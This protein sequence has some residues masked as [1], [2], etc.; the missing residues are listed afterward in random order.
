MTS[1]QKRSYEEFSR[2]WTVPFVSGRLSR[3]ALF[4][5][6]GPL[7]VEIGFGMGIATAI[8]AGQNP[9]VNYLGIEVHRPGIGR[10]LWEI[11]KRGLSNIKIIEG[12]AVEVLEAMDF[13]VDSFHIF[14]P[15]PWPKKRHHKR[16]LIQRPFTGLL[17]RRLK[18]GGYLYMVTDWEDYGHWALAELA[19]TAGLK[20][21]YGDFAGGA[22][23]DFAEEGAGGFARGFAPAQHWRPKTKFEKKGI[24]KNHQVWELMF[25]RG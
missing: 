9:G 11:E 16:L 17:A 5:G 13:E 10:L 25:E 14:F 19:G 8:I 12:D 1:A 6:T 20:N 4:A 15:D 23:G 21:H 7:C 24:A 18:K 2:R 3:D 22:S